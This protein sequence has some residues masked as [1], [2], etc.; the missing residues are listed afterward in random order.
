MKIN[1]RLLARQFI[2]QIINENISIN[3]EYDHGTSNCFKDDRE[4]TSPHDSSNPLE[5]DQYGIV[6][7]DSLYS[8]FDLDNDGKVTPAEYTNHI[9]FHCQYP[10]T[11]DHYNKLRQDSHQSVPC[12]SSY[13]TCSQ[14][15]MSDTESIKDIL[16]PILQMTGVDCHE[17]AIAGLNDVIRCLKDKG[18]F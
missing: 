3:D 7:K 15:F 18:L 16:S 10:E 6:T 13:D 17:S 1:E 11:L 5:V 2:N 9:N 8:H 4:K 12:H 14:H